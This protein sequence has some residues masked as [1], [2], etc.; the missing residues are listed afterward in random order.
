MR[1]PD[2]RITG[3]RVLSAKTRD[4]GSRAAGIL[5]MA[6]NSLHRSQTSLGEFFRWMKARLGVPKAI[7]ATAH[8]LARIIFHLIRDG[9]AYDDS[10][11]AQQDE[12]HRQRK[13]RYLTKQTAECGCSLIP[14][15]E[16]QPQVS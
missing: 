12:R 14:N 3:G 11:F 15:T 6:A 1:C 4:V 8:K 7:T 9:T 5:R 2:N 13:L 10:V 16:V